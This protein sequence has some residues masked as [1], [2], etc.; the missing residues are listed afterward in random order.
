MSK[1]KKHYEYLLS[2]GG[3]KP[4]KEKTPEIDDDFDNSSF[5][6]RI[7]QEMNLSQEC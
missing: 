2:L 4:K 1:R 6:F 5:D 7:S 3:E